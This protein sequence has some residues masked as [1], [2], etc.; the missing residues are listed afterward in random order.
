MEKALPG[1]EDC[2]P[3][4]VKNFVL[5]KISGLDIQQAFKDSLKASIEKNPTGIEIICKHTLKWNSS[6]FDAV[7]FACFGRD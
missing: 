5:D 7:K 3:I 1:F 6:M 4:C 2:N